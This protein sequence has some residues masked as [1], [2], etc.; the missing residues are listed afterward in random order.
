MARGFAIRPMPGFTF[1][2]RGKIQAKGKAKP[3][4]VYNVLRAKPLQGWDDRTA[5]H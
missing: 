4:Q 1:I 2:P 5:S 3:L